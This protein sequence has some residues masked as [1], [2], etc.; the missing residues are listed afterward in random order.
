MT[1]PR[2]GRVL[3]ASIAVV[4]T[5]MLLDEGILFNESAGAPPVWFGGALAA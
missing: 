3:V 1:H 5:G 2:A 4:S